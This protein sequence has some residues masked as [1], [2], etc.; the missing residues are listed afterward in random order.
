MSKKSELFVKIS[1]HKNSIGKIHTLGV[2]GKSFLSY[3]ESFYNYIQSHYYLLTY[4]KE[5]LKSHVLRE[6]KLCSKQMLFLPKSHQISLLLPS[7]SFIPL[8]HIYFP[9]HPHLFHVNSLSNPP[10]LPWYLP[11]SP[12]SSRIPHVSPTYFTSTCTLISRP[13]GHHFP[14]NPLSLPGCLGGG[15]PSKEV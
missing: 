1:C 3:Q 7:P 6:D 12:S 4:S 8:I 9:I 2:N 13:L 10:S 15:M 5:F 14:S 11:L